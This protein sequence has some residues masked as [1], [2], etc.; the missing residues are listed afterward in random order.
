MKKAEIIKITKKE[1]KIIKKKHKKRYL[2]G[3]L[4]A[5]SIVLICNFVITGDDLKSLITRVNYVYNPVNSLY[6]DN[7]SAIFTSGAL[8]EKEALNFII[9]IKTASFNV[10]DNGE[11]IFNVVNSI[12]VMACEDGVVEDTGFTL[13]GVKY[14]K[15]KH[16]MSVYSLIENVNIVGVAKGD[17][18][19]KGQD[20]A[21][22]IQ[23]SQVKLKLYENENIVSN[24][25][26]NQSKIVWGK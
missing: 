6:S 15:I 18:V 17:V 25:K 2:L 12:M 13:D 26:I 1:I 22:A 21:T 20:I 3:T 10:E 14:I 11:M 8:I 7:S 19:K 4:F 24:I 9:P 5:I 23:G 16:T